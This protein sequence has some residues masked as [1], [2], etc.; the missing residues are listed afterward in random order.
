MREKEV[1]FGL[2]KKRLGKRGGLSR[3]MSVPGLCLYK[4]RVDGVREREAAGSVGV[5]QDQESKDLGS[6][7]NPFSELLDD[8]RQIIL[9]L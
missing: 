2:V 4:D 8:H 1:E 5:G 6:C 7:L 3:R 9:L